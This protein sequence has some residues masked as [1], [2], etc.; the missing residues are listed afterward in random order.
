MNI[1]A[2]L[3]ITSVGLMLYTM[4]E[5]NNTINHYKNEVVALKGTIEKI[6]SAASKQYDELF[7]TQAELGRYQMTLEILKDGE[8][9]KAAKTFEHVLTTQ[10]E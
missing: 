5:Q 7:Q 4:Y 3:S 9:V 1:K 10:T 2:I 8:N 6:D